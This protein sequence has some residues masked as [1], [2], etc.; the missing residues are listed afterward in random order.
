MKIWRLFILLGAS[1]SEMGVPEDGVPEPEIPAPHIPQ[2]RA[3]TFA[4]NAAPQLVQKDRL[5]EDASFEF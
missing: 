4:G 2:K 5:V 3:P 1:V